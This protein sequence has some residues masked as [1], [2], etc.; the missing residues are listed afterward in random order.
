MSF[1]RSL[2]NSIVTQQSTLLILFI[3]VAIL[4]IITIIGCFYK[5]NQFIIAVLSIIMTFTGVLI[6]FSQFYREE[7]FQTKEYEF[8]QINKIESHKKND[9]LNIYRIKTYDE[10]L[11]DNQVVAT[12]EKLHKNDTIK[13]KKIGQYIKFSKNNVKGDKKIDN[14]AKFNQSFDY[15]GIDTSLEKIKDLSFTDNYSHKP[16]ILINFYDDS[17]KK[18]NS[19]DVT[20][21]YQLNKDQMIIQFND[22]YTS[23]LKSNIKQIKQNNIKYFKIIVK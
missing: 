19:I 12:T 7:L 3:V 18:I 6:I 4:F 20:H 21:M 14:H 10:D 8:T 1:I 5:W 17:Y 13:Y 11:D 2:I 23:K 9:N 15:E 16:Q 22:K